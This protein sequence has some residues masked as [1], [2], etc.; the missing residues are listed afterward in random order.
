MARISGTGAVLLGTIMKRLVAVIAAL[1]TA[2][3]VVSGAGAQKADPAIYGAL[4]DVTEA[5]ISP[6]GKT[7]A[8]LQN[9]GASSAVLFYDLNNKGAQPIGVGVG[10]ANARSIEWADNDHL[11]V[12]VSQ[13]SRKATS[14]GI[15]TIEF[16]RWLSVSKSDQKA[17]LLFGNEAGFFIPS[18]G[19]FIS[20]L[21]NE[22][23]KVLFARISRSGHFSG[24][25][26][27]GRLN[28]DTVLAYSLF[29]ANLKNGKTKLLK[30]G[31]D[32]TVDWVVS[33]TG[34]PV[35]RIDYN[36]NQSRREIYTIP[37]GTSRFKLLTSI[38][39]PRGA[40]STISFYGMSDK[41]NIVL[42]TTYAGGDK[43]SLVE[44]DL[45]TGGIGETLFRNS[46]YDISSVVYDPRKATATGVRFVDNLPRTYHLNEADRSLQASLA[47][48]LPGAAPMIVSKS[49]D[50]TRVIVEAIY[51]DHPKQFFL[52]DKNARS[53]N[54]LSP[55]Y[56]ALDGK[57]AANKEKYDYVSSDGLQINGFLTVPAGASKQSMPLIVLPHG[58]PESFSDQAFYYWPFFYAARGYLVYQPNFR[59]SDGYGFDFRAAG[60]GEWGRKMQDDI[61]EGVQ[62]LVA[63][64]IADPGRICI[65]GGSYGGYAALAGATLTPDLYACAVSVNGVSNLNGMLGRASQGSGLAED[66]WEVRIGSRFRDG[67]ALNAVS[68]AKIA[69]RAGPPILLIHGK[70][71]TIVPIEQSRQMRNALKTAGKPHEYVVLDGEDHWLSTSAAR[72]E[73]LRTSIEFIDRHIGQ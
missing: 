45:T 71:D 25:A 52:F 6:D 53:L 57:V 49:A 63:D 1:L 40:G 54:M 14:G 41:P 31:E 33:E 69:R 35:A 59:G 17:N 46:T 47:K 73:M 23:G 50:E 9:I 32:N 38:E 58:G 29:T 30:A 68:P 43:R 70:D 61:T 4:P 15:E 28:R 13:S 48:A 8:L 42:A 37:E 11:L 22:P 12:L 64:G 5:Q 20:D 60:Y 72:T 18:A 56:S 24:G 36:A 55:S 26:R 19:S 7:V 21:P 34:D 66:Y 62:K 65:A 2:M 39:E 16:F 67:D 10:K 3:F 44:F 51:T 27:T